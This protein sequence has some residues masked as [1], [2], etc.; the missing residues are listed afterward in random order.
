MLL[1]F[2]GDFRLAII[3]AVTIP[4]S[5]IITF[6]GMQGF[7]FTINMITLISIGISIGTLVT[8]AIIVLE[9]IAR[10][11]NEGMEV[12]KAADYG[13]SEVAIAVFASAMTNVA[14]F[15]PI[16]NMKGITGQFFKPLGL[17]ITTATIVSLLLSFTLVPLMASRMLKAKAQ[18]DDGG[19]KESFA[20]RLLKPVQAG[21]VGFLKSVLHMKFLTLVGVAA[22]FM[23]TLF[24][25]SRMLGTEFFPTVDMG[26]VNIAVELPSGTS[27][28]ATDKV[29][30]T[31]ENRMHEIPEVKNVYSSL[32]GEGTNSGVN[33]GNLTITL[34]D[35]NERD[36]TTSQVSNAMRPMLADIPDAKITVKP[37]SMFGGGGSEADIQVE[38]TGDR[39]S[40]ILALADSVQAK[41][42]AVGGLVD[43][44]SSWKEAKPEIKFIPNRLR[45]DEYG[46]N[47]ATLGFMVRSALSGY[48]AAVFREE[49]DEYTI[50]VQLD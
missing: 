39:M 49:N 17:T 50:R 23:V 1:I 37:L 29:L 27:M 12:R 11:R 47:V 28:H 36:R 18:N 34:V 32:G 10:H 46:M 26:F 7:G 8:N 38:I 48:E 15:V 6:L 3:A 13:A 33:F 43:I 16:A 19:V 45:C 25:V 41:A 21:Y 9:N 2:L 5:I 42:V 31:V 30:A 14:V 20:D 4:T 40:D 22:L 35:K 44:K 24:G